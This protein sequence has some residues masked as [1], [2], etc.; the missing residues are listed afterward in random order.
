MH[1]TR[2]ERQGL[3]VPNLEFG[4]AGM[5]AF[6]GSRRAPMVGNLLPRAATILARVNASLKCGDRDLARLGRTLGNIGDGVL[7]QRRKLELRL[8]RDFPIDAR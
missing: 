2:F 3:L 4:L 7:T 5:V 8:R 1:Y 6:I